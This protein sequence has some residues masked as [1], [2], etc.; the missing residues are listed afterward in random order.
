[1]ATASFPA[2]LRLYS[3]S[4]VCGIFG[5]S[6]ETLRRWVKS[7]TFPQPVMIGR[8]PKW[9]YADIQKGIEDRRAAA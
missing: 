6:G 2:E 4:E 8:A 9:T 1:M 5:I 3:R 7:K